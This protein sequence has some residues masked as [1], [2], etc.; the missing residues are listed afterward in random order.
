MIYRISILYGEKKPS[1]WTNLSFYGGFGEIVKRY[2][3]DF[4]MNN[5]KLGNFYDFSKKD[6]ALPA[7]SLLSYFS[8]VPKSGNERTLFPHHTGK[9]LSSPFIRPA[10]L[11]KQSLIKSDRRLLP[12]PGKPAALFRI[13]IGVNIFL[14]LAVKCLIR[15][16]EIGKYPKNITIMLG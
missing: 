6:T 8:P 9:L 16:W 5:K 4:E 3:R 13:K 10:H 11:I 1:Q 2:C 7:A 15:K 12:L 14:D